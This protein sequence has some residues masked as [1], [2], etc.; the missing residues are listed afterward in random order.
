LTPFSLRLP[1]SQI[2]IRS[3]ALLLAEDSSRKRLADK[4]ELFFEVVFKGEAAPWRKVEE[5]PTP[6]V[7][8]AELPK[9]ISSE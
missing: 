3:S 1:S 5:V 4:L 7:S 2:L 8:P 6:E 9:E